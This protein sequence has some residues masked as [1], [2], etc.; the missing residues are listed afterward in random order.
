MPFH[1]MT[2]PAIVMGLCGAAGVAYISTIFARARRQTDYTPVL[3]DWIWHTALPF[4]AYGTL[5]V[6]P[7]A[8]MR[9]GDVALFAV[10]ATSL[11]L[12]FVGIHNAW[13]TVTYITTAQP[14]LPATTD[15]PST[16][17]PPTPSPSTASPPHPS[18]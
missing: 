1:T 2:G 9:G 17:S 11:L 6:S 8:I 15:A 4:L 12:L 5:F 14:G 3:E 16:S 10:A 7:F 13:D 18:P